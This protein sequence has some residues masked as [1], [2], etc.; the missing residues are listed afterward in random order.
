MGLF[1]KK[2]DS[3]DKRERAQS[4]VPCPVQ[5]KAHSKTFHLI[6]KGNGTKAK[7]GMGGHSKTHNWTPTLTMRYFNMTFNNLMEIYNVLMVE[8]TPYQRQLEMPDC[9]SELL[10]AL[11]QHGKDMRVRAPDHPDHKRDVKNALTL[12]RCRK[13]ARIQKGL[14]LV[15]ET[16]LIHQRSSKHSTTFN[17]EKLGGFTKAR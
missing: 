11:M 5:N 15:V 2:R 17:G 13:F 3:D 8:H 9:I 4:E 6:N 10:H 7:Y 16:Q 12:D 14:S 1:Q